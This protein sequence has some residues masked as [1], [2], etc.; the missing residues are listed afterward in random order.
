MELQHIIGNTFVV[1][2]A[3]ALLPL[4][5]C[6]E[7]DVILLDTGLAAN[8]RDGLTAL[9]EDNDFHLKG[10]ICT[11]AHFDHTGNARY[12]QQRYA[13]PVAM[14]LIEAGIAASPDAYRGNYA[15]LT[16]G[17]SR[18]LFSEE[19]V[20]ADMT[21]DP[22]AR[23][24]TFCGV[25]FS[26]LS[27]PGHTAGQ[28]GVV[29]PDSVAYL[30]DCLIGEKTMGSAKLP[31]VMNLAQDMDSKNALLSLRCKCYII[32]HKEVLTDIRPL[33][34]Y[35]LEQIQTR[36]FRLLDCLKDGMNIEE[37]LGAFCEAS[38]VH[39]HQDLKLSI[40]ER[41]FAQFLSYLEDT[42]RINMQRESGVKHYTKI[43]K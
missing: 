20:V 14:P 10:M 40:L 17:Q 32:S 1:E 11:H 35:D 33:I 19:W 26:I 6:G 7:K 9:L 4:Y 12:L 42:G 38:E 18:C 34:A 2:A 15:Y 8:D 21:I 30:A 25:P 5:R 27:L 31:T 3:T 24:F 23:A 41:N 29:T 37:W 16:Y 39:T 13:C 43:L 36:I 28:I 22:Q